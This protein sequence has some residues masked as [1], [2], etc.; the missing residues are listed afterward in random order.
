MR[1]EK[2]KKPNKALLFFFFLSFKS[3][4]QDLPTLKKIFFSPS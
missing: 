2:K 3:L 4:L 1:D